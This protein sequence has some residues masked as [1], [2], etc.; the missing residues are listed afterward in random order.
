MK[1][2]KD[3]VIAENPKP[4]KPLTIEANKTTKIKYIK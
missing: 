2:N 3:T 4:E 1:L